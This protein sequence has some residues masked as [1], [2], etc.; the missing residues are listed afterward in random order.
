[1]S[2]KNI[3]IPARAGSKGWPGKNVALF[4]QTAEKIPNEFR[5]K[6]IVSTDD[7]QIVAMCEKYKYQLHERSNGTAEDGSDIKSVMREI[8]ATGDYKSSDVLVMLYLTYPDRDWE[9]VTQMY[10]T[11]ISQQSRS[12]LCRQP[13]KTHPCLTMYEGPGSTG[14]QVIKH[15][16]YQRQ[17]YP[18]CFEISHYICMFRVGEVSRLN[19]NMYNTKTQFYSIPRTIDVDSKEDYQ[20]FLLHQG[21]DDNNPD[22]L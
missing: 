16:H 19:K 9:H 20:Q 8:I 18:E 5:N 15:S 10:N 14:K 7:L 12:M 2:F 13:V 3:I 1:M 4:D 6:V 21:S 17:Q 22:T 11:F